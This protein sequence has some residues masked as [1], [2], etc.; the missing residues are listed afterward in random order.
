MNAAVAFSCIL[1][2]TVLGEVNGFYGLSDL[3]I[4]S[5]RCDDEAEFKLGMA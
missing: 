2:R 1:L 4:T 3:R 5:L